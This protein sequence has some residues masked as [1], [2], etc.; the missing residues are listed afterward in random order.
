MIGKTNIIE[1]ENA[2]IFHHYKTILN[3]VSLKLN[4]GD[5]IYII[6]ITGSGKSS[7]LKTLYSDIPQKWGK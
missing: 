4:K 5:F 2:T 3:N 1:I 7:L 6:G